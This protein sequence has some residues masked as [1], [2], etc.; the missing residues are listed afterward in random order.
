MLGNS[1]LNEL[2]VENKIF[3]PDEIL[4]RLRKKIIAS[5][6][7]KGS[8]DRRDGMDMAICTWNKLNNTMEFAGANNKLWIIRN[9]KLIEYTGNKM[10][11]G[12]YEGELSPFT[13]H[14]IQLEKNDLII[15]T[16]DGFADQFGGENSKKFMSKNLKAFLVNN[17][18]LPLENQK[19]ELVNL[20]NSWKGNNEQVDD[21]SLIM[22]KV[23]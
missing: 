16:T 23:V 12:N 5:L 14:D 22:I 13:C 6:E 10:P 2:V 4:N 7:Q 20:F 21:I 8:A 9:S 19:Y 1:F 18:D 11:V 3:R 17:S 15:L